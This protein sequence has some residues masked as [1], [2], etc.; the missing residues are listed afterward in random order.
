ML[1]PVPVDLCRT[2]LYRA[3][4]VYKFLPDSGSADSTYNKP[5]IGARYSPGP[6]S[7]RQRDRDQPKLKK[8]YILQTN[9]DF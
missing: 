7:Q 5:G 1:V 2:Q 6:A 3:R 8:I 4:A 9:D